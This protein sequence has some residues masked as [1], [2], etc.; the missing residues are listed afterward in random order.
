[1]IGPLAEIAEASGCQIA[2]HLYSGPI[3]GAANIQL[4]AT[5]PNLLIIEGI[6]DWSGFH[7]DLLTQPIQ[8]SDGYVTPSRKPG[9]G[10]ALNEA[11]ALAH[12]YV[13]SP[14]DATDLHLGMHPD[15]IR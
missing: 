12:P 5:L 7:A 9:L 1:M 4:A 11:V 6:Q 13:P 15:P 3:L 8:W 14:D 2:P 10:T